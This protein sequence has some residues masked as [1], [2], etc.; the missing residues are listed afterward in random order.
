MSPESRV[1]AT[2]VAVAD[3]DLPRAHALV[4]PTASGKTAMS[5]ALAARFAIEIVNA[6][7]LQAYR[8]LEIGTD[9]PSA[10]LRARIPHHL[11]DV[12]DPDEPFSAGE[13]A[14]RAG[15]AIADI[16]RRGKVPLVVGGS[17]LYHRALF[18]GLS[19]LPNAVP[20]IRREL[21]IELQR[22]G[23]QSMWRELDR[24]DPETAARLHPS[25]PQ[26]ILRALEIE[27][28]SGRPMSRWLAENPPVPRA[29]VGLRLGLTVPRSILY[30]RIADRVYSM[31][32]RGWVAEVERLQELG[33]DASS[34]AYQAI[35]YRH[36]LRHVRGE[37]ALQDAIDET[38]RDTRRYAKRQITWFRKEPAIHWISGLDFE[39]ATPAVLEAMESQERPLR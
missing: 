20:A 9:K 38:I 22:N 6:D 13:F 8:H 3:G 4:G 24:V 21:E 25:D 36:M 31:V 1:D 5:E 15:L 39:E 12:L 11:V 26:R 33:F 14:R 28:A 19:E 17:G 30:H 27:R 35:G 29:V 37:T 23:V 2:L 18:T 16:R 32:A 7:A 10:D 34:P